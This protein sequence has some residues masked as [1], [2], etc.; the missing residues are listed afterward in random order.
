M[1]WELV[2]SS[3]HV[4]AVVS[5][6]RQNLE[7][8]IKQGA[9]QLKGK[10]RKYEDMDGQAGGDTK[11]KKNVFFGKLL[12]WGGEGGDGGFFFL[13]AVPQ[14]PDERSFVLA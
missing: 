7:P 6:S 5:A 9:R 10:G 2:T 13:I 12:G 4:A 3:G 14:P 1:L 8:R 11:G